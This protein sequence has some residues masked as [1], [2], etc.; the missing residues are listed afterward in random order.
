M[1][2]LNKNN[3]MKNKNNSKKIASV[4]MSM[5]VTHLLMADDKR[6]CL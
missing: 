6:R 4:L 2:T 1:D 3:K 5:L